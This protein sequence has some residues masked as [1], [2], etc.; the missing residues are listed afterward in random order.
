MFADDTKIWRVISKAEDSDDLQQDLN[1][2][3][4]WSD[5]WLLRF[6]PEKCKVMHIGYV[7]PTQ[8]YMEGWG[9]WK[10]STA[11]SNN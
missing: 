5:K 11:T 1:K 9:K 2:L 3:A 7:H 8:Y 10:I 6:N 4:K